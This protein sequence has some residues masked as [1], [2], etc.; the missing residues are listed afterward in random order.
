MAP[1]ACQYREIGAY[2]AKTNQVM[3]S[4]KGNRGWHKAGELAGKKMA[5]LLASK[6]NVQ[7]EE[8]ILSFQPMIA[9]KFVV[10]KVVKTKQRRGMVLYRTF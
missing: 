5:A 4:L 10:D 6:K 7:G 3:K 1:Q 8:V 9:C 2:I